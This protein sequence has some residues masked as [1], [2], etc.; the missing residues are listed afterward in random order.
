MNRR[1]WLA[2]A[3]A[4]SATM[5]AGCSVSFE[6]GLFAECRDPL[7]RGGARLLA[8]GAW[9]K[10]HAENV[11]DVHVHLLG[12]GRSGAGVYLAPSLDKPWSPVSMARRVFFRNAACITGDEAAWDQAAL[13]RLTALAD[14][15]PRGA[16]LMLLA[17]DY[18]H[19]ENGKERP[20]LTTMAIPNEY[21]QKVAASRPDRFEWIASVHP[22]REDAIAALEAA[23][24]KG[25]RA[26]KW[27]PPTMAID[28]G[29]ARCR[30][31]YEALKR[32]DLPLL[33]HVGDEQAVAGASRGELGDPT[34]LRHPL[35]QG[36]RVIAAHCATLGE[37]NFEKFA[38]L[39]DDPRYEKTL[40]GDISAVTQLNRAKLLPAIIERT[41]WHPRL[42]NGSDYPLPG[43]LPIFS[44]KTLASLGVLDESLI[45]ALRELRESN[46]LVFDFT[47]KRNLRYKGIKFPESVFE[48]RRFFVTPAQAGV[49]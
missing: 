46:A 47:L 36:V 5:L 41:A 45:P 11:W 25:A 17:F 43:V 35:E 6:Q 18:T 7:P 19:D 14:T 27:L 31:F 4:G 8:A 22:Y 34:L 30:P 49:Q 42:L 12:N 32:L 29:H 44:L 23:K 2:G 1:A 21:A 15:L 33:V 20:D 10:L 26:V 48:T 38:K 13:A 39:M 3:M 28:M 9:N 40:F 16:K 37:G 24:A